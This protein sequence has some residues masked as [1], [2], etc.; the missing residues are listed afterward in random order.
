[1]GSAGFPN[2]IVSYMMLFLHEFGHFIVFT[3]LFF[4]INYLF[5]GRFS[6]KNY[7]IGLFATIL[8]DLDHLIDYFIYHGFYFDLLGFLQGDNFEL[9]QKA[10]VFFHSWEL[11]IAIFMVYVLFEQKNKKISSYI[12][13]I[14]LGLTAH[15][16]YDVVTYDIAWG[17]YFLYNRM[18]NAF[19]IL[20]L[21]GVY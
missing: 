5:F 17:G 14:V 18:V 10:Y 19:D 11:V 3:C 6:S 13:M 7:L 1:M 15:I 8:I 9:N 4:A 12:L 21:E 16:S 2:S 20:V